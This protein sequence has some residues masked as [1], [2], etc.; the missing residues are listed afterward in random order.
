MSVAVYCPFPNITSCTSACNLSE[1]VA[2]SAYAPR[3]PHRC[4]L[5]R[6]TNLLTSAESAA[7][8]A[9]FGGVAIAAGAVGPRRASA[10]TGSNALQLQTAVIERYGSEYALRWKTYQIGKQWHIVITRALTLP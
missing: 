7:A 4:T 3:Y 5:I 1:H 9:I 8:L 10:N 2:V 6:H